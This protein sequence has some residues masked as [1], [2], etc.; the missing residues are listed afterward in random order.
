MVFLP[1]LIM[2]KGA[3]VSFIA[4]IVFLLMKMLSICGHFDKLSGVRQEGWLAQYD[5]IMA[6]SDSDSFVLVNERQK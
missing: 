5:R 6:L 2:A 4:C 3:G 1:L